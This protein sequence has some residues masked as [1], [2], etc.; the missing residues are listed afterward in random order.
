M[1]IS[2]IISI[3]CGLTLIRKAKEVCFMIILFRKEFHYYR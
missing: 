2:G 1:D 3:D